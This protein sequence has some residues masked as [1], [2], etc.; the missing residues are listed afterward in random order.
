MTE[1]RDR[2]DAAQGIE[3]VL[4][5][6][7][8][9]I[10]RFLQ[11]RGA[12]DA[13]EDLFQDLWMRLTERA[14]GPVADPL[15]YVMRA[16]NNLMLDRYRS[17]RQRELRDAAWGEAAAVQKPSVET[18]LISREQLAQVE[19]AITATGDR[20]ARIFRR[21]RVDG[22][23]QREIAVE[24]GVSLSTVEADLRRVYAAL[25]AV[26]RQFDA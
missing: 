24:M 5:A 20:S 2:T 7:R 1:A 11:L 4:L 13:A 15:P 21:F 14:S 16:A 8:D 19:Q 23:A 18:L 10:V 6:N 17:A 9:R 12:G 26:R 22:L 3:G 25:A